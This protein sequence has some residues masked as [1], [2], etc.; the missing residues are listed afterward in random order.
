MN[1][2]KIKLAQLKNI[3]DTKISKYFVKLPF[4]R[5]IFY[6]IFFVFLYIFLFYQAKNLEMRSTFP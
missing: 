4:S 2:I 6:P 3:F 5:K 1:K